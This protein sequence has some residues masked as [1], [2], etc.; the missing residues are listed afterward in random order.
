[1][2]KVLMLKIKISVTIVTIIIKKDKDKREK[3]YISAMNLKY[4][5]NRQGIERKMMNKNNMLIAV[6][7][8]INYQII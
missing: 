6:H 3:V 5:I 8:K 2:R 1:M 4:T 7:L